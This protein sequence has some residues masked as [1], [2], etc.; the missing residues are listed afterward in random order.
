[1]KSQQP[2]PAIHLVYIESDGEILAHEDLSPV[3]LTGQP[4]MLE[5]LIPLPDDAPVAMMPG[6]LAKG[7][8]ASG[9]IIT[10]PSSDGWCTD[11]FRLVI[12]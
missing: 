4:I 10:L 3:D 2:D 9:N 7:M 11:K 12:K 6:R 5:D 1:M 8:D